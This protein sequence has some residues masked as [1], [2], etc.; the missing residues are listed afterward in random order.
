MIAKPIAPETAAS[1][2]TVIYD[3]PTHVSEEEY[4]RVWAEQGYEW[5]N[6]EM[7]KVSAGNLTHYGVV[8]YLNTL[9][10]IYLELNPIGSLVGEPIILKFAETGRYR[11]PDLMVV[12]KANSVGVLTH[13]AVIGAADICIEVVSPESVER[14]YATKL[15]EYEKAGVQEYWII[16]PDRERAIFN[17]RDTDGHFSM[18]QPDAE[19]RY[20]TPLLPGFFLSV[21][22]LW[23]DPLPRMIDTVEV[24]RAMFPDTPL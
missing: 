6:G 14:D 1:H 13:T 2:D 11:E 3:F 19:A 15:L 8:D 21:P 18:I 10:K 7:N 20:R 9:L 22:V 24:V 5:V 16:D 4:L 17:Q 12:L 23:T